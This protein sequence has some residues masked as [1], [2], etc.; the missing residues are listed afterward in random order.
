MLS[1]PLY[2]AIIGIGSLVIAFQSLKT[3][4]FGDP[5]SESILNTEF[6][7]FCHY[8]ISDIGYALTQQAIHARLEDI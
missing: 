8:A 3:R 5:E 6:F 7:Q 4:V 1:H 2:N